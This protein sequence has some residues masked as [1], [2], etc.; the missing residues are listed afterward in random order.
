MCKKFLSCK[1]KDETY[2]FHRSFSYLSYQIKWY[3]HKSLLTYSVDVH[4]LLAK[5]VLLDSLIII[6]TIFFN[7]YFLYLNNLDLWIIT[8]KQRKLEM[9]IIKQAI[10]ILF[11]FVKHTETILLYTFW[12]ILERTPSFLGSSL[13]NRLQTEQYTVSYSNRPFVA[14]FWGS[15]WKHFKVLSFS[16]FPFHV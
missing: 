12:N 9:G 1:G 2:I 6:C 11:T 13:P 14:S 5:G 7:H 15:Y 10:Y 8:T 4:W 3:E 16:F